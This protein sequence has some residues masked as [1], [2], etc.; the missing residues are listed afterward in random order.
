M[1]CECCAC[2]C[3]QIP[4]VAAVTVAA[5]AAV[6][7]E[8]PDSRSSTPDELTP[9]LAQHDGGGGRAGGG[10]GDG[11]STDAATDCTTVA[12]GTNRSTS[13]GEYAAERAL[14]NLFCSDAP[15]DFL[16]V[17]SVT[18]ECPTRDIFTLLMVYIR[19]G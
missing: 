18:V 17:Y 4:D 9:A 6:V 1:T 16:N 5:A 7:C 14:L 8:S 3:A 2:M 11:R 15:I 12:A 19:R 13:F 10:S